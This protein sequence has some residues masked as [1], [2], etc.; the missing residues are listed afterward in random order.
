MALVWFDKCQSLE[1]PFLAAWVDS[2]RKVG[3]LRRLTGPHNHLVAHSGG[4]LIPSWGIFDPKLEN[5]RRI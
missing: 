5:L 1:Q 4:A 2:Q 3:L